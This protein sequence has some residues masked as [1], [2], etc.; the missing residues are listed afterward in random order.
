L[1][2]CRGRSIN[3]RYFQ[4]LVRLYDL[5]CLQRRIFSFII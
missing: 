1:F 2:T 4:G 3:F 5:C